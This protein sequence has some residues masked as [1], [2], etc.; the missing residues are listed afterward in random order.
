MLTPAT[1]GGWAMQRV[2]VPAR[3]LAEHATSRVDRVP[4][5]ETRAGRAEMVI[6]GS[7]GQAAWLASHPAAW[8][9]LAGH[10][11]G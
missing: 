6:A 7:A 4:G 11:F 1:I 8:H 2:V 5:R 10:R 9:T 3:V